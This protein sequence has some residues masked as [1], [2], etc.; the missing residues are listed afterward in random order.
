[1]IQFLEYS[2]GGKRG[3][4]RFTARVHAIL[5]ARFGDITPLEYIERP[6]DL[7]NPIK[8]ALSALK[9]VKDTAPDLVVADISSG[10]RNVLGV[11]L[12]KYRKKYVIIIIQGQ[13]MNYKFAYFP[14]IRLMVQLC[15][16]YLLRRADIVITN[17]NYMADF[18]G[19]KGHHKSNII[20]AR[21]GMAIN[22]NERS[23]MPLVN[24][25]KLIGLL[26]IGDCTRVKGID[27]MV[28]ALS[29]LKDLNIELNLAGSFSENSTY[30]KR[31]KRIIKDN[32][33]IERVQ[34]LG[35]LDKPKMEDIFARS[36]IYVQPSLSEGYGIAMA[37][38]LAFGLPVVAS[39]VAAIPEM[40]EDGV[41]GIL[42]PPKDPAALADAIR[43]LISDSELWDRIH[44]NNLA[45]AKTLP[46]WDDFDR[47]LERELIPE[48]ERL[49]GLSSKRT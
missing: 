20:V 45:K 43:R 41:N 10:I 18:A 7:K 27:Y 21:P 48:I 29:H 33:L 9:R 26:L 1:M 15:E 40:I 49:T 47:T 38:A 39:R 13:R 24:K 16:S 28:R 14:L 6:P 37:E 22:L 3:G 30:Y 34:F 11:A 36:R 25:S 5:K 32:N 46:T 31:I 17:S 2:A 44:R 19:K 42:V 8:A 12:Q 35:F 4:E 23:E